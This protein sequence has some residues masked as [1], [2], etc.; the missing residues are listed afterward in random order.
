MTRLKKTALW[1]LILSLVL[2]LAGLV[3]E[4]IITKEFGPSAEL[5]GYSIAFSFIALVIAM[6]ATGFNNVFLP[7]YI[8]RKR[9]GIDLTDQNANGLLNRTIVIFVIISI[10]GW[11]GSSWFVPL[12]FPRMSVAVE[13]IAVH[14]TQIFFIFMTFI[15]LSALLDSYLQS[16]RILVPS[17][18]AK[19]LATLLAA[20]FAV[21]F[22]DV[23]GIY[24]VAYGFVTGTVLGV[25]LQVLYLK[26]SD[27]QWKPE[28][29]IEA[30]FKKAF[31]ILFIPSLLNSAVGQVNFLVNKSF[32]A[33]TFDEA[34]TYLG[35]ASM[36]T[37]IPNAIYATTLVT[38]FFTLMSEQAADEKAFKDTFFKGMETSL[39]I[40]LPV[41]VGL[42]LVGD[43]AIAFIFEGGKFTA[44]HTDQTYMALLWYAPTIVFQGMQ[45]ILSKSMY[46]RGKTSVVFRISVTTIF[47]NLMMNWM[48]VD[49]F[50]YLALAF[51]ASIVSIYFFVLSMLVIYKDLGVAEL[52]R[53]FHMC[54]RV[55]I[56]TMI[57]GCIVLGAKISFPIKTWYPLFQLG[58]WVPMGMIVYVI[59]LRLFYPIGF[60]RLVGL[61][62]RRK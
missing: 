28:L 8:K 53:F 2:K 39:I 32:A 45:L 51:S 31:M 41:A 33:G 44:E 12:I 37:S 9:E 27:Y 5:A 11:Y 10:I 26:K 13:P 22:R 7:I 3:R 30:D 40:L 17:Q 54:W 43:A 47:L 36:I 24:A 25:L 23:W 34:V 14:I 18:L 55:L 19:L 15:A 4:S 6:I 42:A 60:D 62:I 48:L 49:Q 56:P 21:F 29:V 61:A 46:A 38:I 59:S 50:G 1:T 20:L 16:R 52:R 35:N 57:M 58:V